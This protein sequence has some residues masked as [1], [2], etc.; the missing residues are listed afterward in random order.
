MATHSPQRASFF[1]G[2]PPVFTSS[3]IA[4][5][6]ATQ[7]SAYTA[8]IASMVTD[9]DAGDTQTFSKVSGPAWLTIAANGSISGTPTF[10][11]VG[12]TTAE[13][14][15]TDLDTVTVDIPPQASPRLFTAASDT[16]AV[17]SR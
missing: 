9:A 10:A 8:S 7:S 1:N 12:A 4:L 17:M 15:A 11:D 16:R 2:Q 5:A 14:R 6:T 3:P 13:V